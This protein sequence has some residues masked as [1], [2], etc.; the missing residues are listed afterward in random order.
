MHEGAKDR[1]QASQG[2][3]PVDPNDVKCVRFEFLDREKNAAMLEDFLGKPSPQF[4]LI[5]LHAC[6]DLSPSTIRLFIDNPNARLLVNVGC[7]Y[8]A[9]SITPTGSFHAFPMSASLQRI[10]CAF[11]SASECLGQQSMRQAAQHSLRK[12]AAVYV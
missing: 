3:P 9:L 8:Q 1:Q 2:M 11:P 7:C 6:G 12:Q 4:G 5:T 10:F